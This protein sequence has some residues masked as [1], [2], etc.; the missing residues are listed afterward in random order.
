MRAGI[1][2]VNS[3]V[4]FPHPE[5]AWPTVSAQPRSTRLAV[6]FKR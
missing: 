2:A 4:A 5:A 6:H 3:G 1:A